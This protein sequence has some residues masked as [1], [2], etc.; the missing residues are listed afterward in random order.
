[1]WIFCTAWKRKSET[2]TPARPLK[3]WDD[4][5]ESSWATTRSTGQRVSSSMES[6][7]MRGAMRSERYCWSSNSASSTS[8]RSGGWDAT[9]VVF[10][11]RDTGSSLTAAPGAEPAAGR[12]IRRGW[13]EAPALVR[14]FL[15]ASMRRREPSVKRPVVAPGP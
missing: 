2:G 11:P 6:A 9:Y 8:A 5:Q 13:N 4:V 3:Y 15:G 14:D 7:T 1:M 12:N 10:S